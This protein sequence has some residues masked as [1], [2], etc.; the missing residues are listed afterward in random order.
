M[1][2]SWEASLHRWAEAGLV[3]PQTAARIREWEGRRGGGLGWPVWLALGLGGLMLVAGVLLFV[4]AQWEA[5]SP[6]QR[7]AIV[8]A[9]V[10][11]F[12][13]AGAYAAERSEGLALTL[14]ACGT[15]ALGG[16]IFLA[17]QIFHLQEHWPGGLMLWAFGAWAG[18][19]LRRDWAQA[20]LAA[21]LT[22]AWLGAE[23]IASTSDRRGAAPL[24][25]GLLGLTLAYLGAEPSRGGEHSGVRRGLVWIGAL[26]LMPAALY[27]V[28]SAQGG[29]AQASLSTARALAGWAVALGIPLA[30]GVV[31]RGRDVA[32]I[33]AGLGWAV[34]GATLT[35]GA[36]GVVPYL[37]SVFLAGGI[38][39]WGVKERRGELINLGTAGFALT[40]TVFYFSDV[41]DRLG[42]SAS[43]IG[44][45]LLFLGGGYLL[46]RARRSLL[47]RVQ[48]AS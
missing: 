40:V 15:V 44:L 43:L 33:A 19:G 12:H 2:H 11:A 16:G 22:P 28:L 47:A 48:E 46:E 45:G 5:L 9:A 20:L 36:D 41:M 34:V 26:G 4:A 14:H 39:A 29:T 23:W 1:P 6:S 13:L 18:W 31:L 7:F 30:A 38:I 21:L 24:A 10:A 37:W 42:R 35:A 27:L 3:D 25:V 8:L 32:P 17:G